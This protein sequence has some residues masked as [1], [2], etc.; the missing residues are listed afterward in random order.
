MTRP[1]PSRPTAPRAA[2]PAAPLDLDEADR[3]LL[4]ALQSDSRRSVQELAELAGLSPSPAWRRVRRMEEA[5]LIARHVA[6][7]SPARLGLRALAY[8]QVALTDHAEDTLTRFD[9]FVQTSPQIVECAS[10]TGESDYLLKI[11][12]A[13]PEALEHFL[14]RRLLATGLVRAT[15][16]LFA[17][18]QTKSTT[19]L[20]V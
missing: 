19:A 3:R 9:R 18:R 1:T 11:V 10:I 6:L 16:T 12:A 7:L 17:L 20:P 2:D 5:G 14:M 15:S 13:D 8:V 4:A